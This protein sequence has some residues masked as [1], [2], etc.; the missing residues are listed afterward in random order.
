VLAVSPDGKYG[1]TEQRDG[2][3]ETPRLVVWEMATGK[4]VVAS[5]RHAALDS[6]PVFTPDGR[7]VVY[8]NTGRLLRWNVATG[9]VEWSALTGACW[10]SPGG[11]L[12]LVRTR[13]YYEINPQVPTGI[14][15]ELELWDV[16][17]GKLLQTLRHA[18]PVWNK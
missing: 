18:E 10:F 5:A 6:G 12:A 4:E 17:E 9:R 7:R 13:S 3:P 1:V 15:I 14:V 11:R 8:V 16:V 2:R